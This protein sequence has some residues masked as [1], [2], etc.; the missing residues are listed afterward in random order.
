MRKPYQLHEFAYQNLKKAGQRHWNARTKPSSNEID[1]NDL[2]FLEDA[3]AQPWAPK[4]GSVI[5]FGTGTGSLLRWFSQRGFEGVGVDIS[6]TALSLAKDQSAG[7][8]LKYFCADICKDELK[9]SKKFEVVLDGRCLHCIVGKSDRKKALK[10]ARAQVGKN[11]I[12]LLL[13]MAS[14]INKA[15]FLEAYPEQKLLKSVC[16]AP[17]DGKDKIWGIKQFGGKAYLPTRQIDHW[18]TI[19]SEV[20]AAGFKPL[21]TRVNLAY[22][23]CAVSSLCLA[24]VAN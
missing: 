9:T 2:R 16:Y 5:E 7:K 4:L 12:Y 14:P 13:T 11:G 3:L 18:H 24:A 10:N 22:D 23:K 6:P 15:V 8:D 21:V 1:P 19:I 20:V 17:F